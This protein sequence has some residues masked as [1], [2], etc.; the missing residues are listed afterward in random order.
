MMYTYNMKKQTTFTLS[1]E[2]KLIIRELSVNYGVSM[3]AIIEMA[4]RYLATSK[5]IPQ[6]K[7]GAAI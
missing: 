5:R 6:E 2:A 4:V 7:R 1:P 3:T